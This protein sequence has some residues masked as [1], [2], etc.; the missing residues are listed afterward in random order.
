MK[1]LIIGASGKIGRY[2]LEFGSANY[3]YTYNKRKIRKGIYFDICKSNL[4]KLCKKFCVNKIILLSGISDPGEC[5]RNKKYSNL[6]NVTK[7][8]KIIDYIIKKDIYFIFFSTEFIFSGNKGNYGEGDLAKTKQLYGNQ[9]YL[10][11]KYITKRTKNFS[12]LRIAKT[13]GDKLDDNTLISNFILSLKNGKR[14]FSVATDQKFNPLYVRDLQKIIKLFL[15]REM[16]GIFNVGGPEQL[17]RYECIKRVIN[18][19]K[20]KNKIILK[21]SKL[22]NFQFLDKRPLNI[23][24]NINKIKR[25]IKFKLTK[26][27]EVAKK[28]VRRNKLNEKLF[29]RR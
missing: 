10:I 3:I 28:I 6:I 9:K 14:E 2:F 24:M 8:K 15:K 5:Y 16:K 1:T 21:K 19:F 23:T 20:S 13:Y 11:E 27:D 29:N 7:T 25:I 12:I 18:Q 22:K 26:I 17:S 4:D